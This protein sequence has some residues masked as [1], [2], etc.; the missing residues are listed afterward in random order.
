M[1]KTGKGGLKARTHGQ[2]S[3]ATGDTTVV[4]TG[5]PKSLNAEKLLELLDKEF[6]CCYDFFYLPMYLDQ[7][8]NTGLAYINFRDHAKAVECQH[9]F[10]GGID[11]GGHISD[12][13][14]K[15]QWSSI[16]GY[17]ANITRHRTADWTRKNVPEDCKPMA[18]DEQGRRLPSLD[19][20][21]PHA[22][23]PA[24]G[25][26]SKSRKPSKGHSWEDEWYGAS[27]SHSR[28]GG[29][30]PG[31]YTELDIEDSG[32]S[33][34]GCIG[35]DFKPFD[36]T[37]ACFDNEYDSWHGMGTMMA[38]EEEDASWGNP[39]EGSM[40]VSALDLYLLGVEQ[41]S[42]EE[43]A[44]QIQA[45]QSMF[46]TQV[47]ESSVAHWEN[48][49]NYADTCQVEF[50]KDEDA[51]PG[52]VNVEDVFY[53]T[54]PPS[55]AIPELPALKHLQ[56]VTYESASASPQMSPSST[57][58]EPG[59][60]GFRKYACPNCKLMFAKWSAC[61]HH[62]A[63]DM[64]CWCVLGKARLPSDVTELQEKCRATAEEL[65]KDCNVGLSFGAAFVDEASKDKVPHFQ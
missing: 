10:E 4:L 32:Q 30:W 35:A 21:A 40:A 56:T 61:Q 59:Q 43:D 6:P 26:G 18:F 44:D 2:H 17:D 58:S 12:R 7:L 22:P 51:L 65:Q 33:G 57:A 19:V 36:D 27:K 47:H 62:L 31:W 42:D 46:P 16:Q 49:A 23:A 64:N 60:L 5:L 24:F 14:C 11:W 3:W 55:P 52:A 38:A 45:M 29:N 37:A 28:K 34:S 41:N 15:A 48:Y 13:P 54:K 53:Q 63:S 50:V 8:E 9:F 39:N 20:F 1:S 25:K